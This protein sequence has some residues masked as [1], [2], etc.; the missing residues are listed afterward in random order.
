MQ[1]LFAIKIK[2]DRTENL[3]IQQAFVPK[4]RQYDAAK[5]IESPEIKRP[6]FHN[7]YIYLIKNDIYHGEDNNFYFAWSNH[8]KRITILSLYRLSAQTGENNPLRDRVYKLVLR[9]IGKIYGTAPEECGVM[10]YSNSL[11]ALDER[12]PYYCKEDVTRLKK[13]GVLRKIAPEGF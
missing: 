5:I 7:Y 13:F 11:Y 8:D 12:Y 2:T 3:P 9:R 1:A 10:R 6:G 4:R